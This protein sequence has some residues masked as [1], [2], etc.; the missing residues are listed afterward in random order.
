MQKIAAKWGKEQGNFWCSDEDSQLAVLLDT[1][2]PC[3]L[4]MDVVMLIGNCHLKKACN[5]ACGNVSISRMRCSLGFLSCL[6][7]GIVLRLCTLHY[8]TAP[9]QV[10]FKMRALALK[11][12][13]GG[14]QPC[15][16]RLRAW[17]EGVNSAS[18]TAELSEIYTLSPIGFG[19]LVELFISILRSIFQSDLSIEGSGTSKKEYIWFFNILNSLLRKHKFKKIHSTKCVEEPHFVLIIFSVVECK[20]WTDFSGDYISWAEISP[21]EVKNK[22]MYVS[23]L[24]LRLWMWVEL[25]LK[26]N[27]FLLNT[28]RR[29]RGNH[30]KCVKLCLFRMSHTGTFL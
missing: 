24:T 1:L 28:F 11:P 10:L 5:A 19:S 2:N 16:L 15:W 21:S 7:R 18:S 25:W 30:K 8:L 6:H 20:K 14:T 4:D 29:E 9:C 13:M 23:T 27:S 22:R 12:F 26:W 17:T 3:F